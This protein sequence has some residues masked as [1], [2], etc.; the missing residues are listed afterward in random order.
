MD[1]IKGFLLTIGN[2][3]SKYIILAFFTYLNWQASILVLNLT[4]NL[5]S[6][7]M[8]IN[9]LCLTMASPLFRVGI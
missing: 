8:F 6:K 7:L 5:R 9:F 1:Q 2:N 4:L 3:Y